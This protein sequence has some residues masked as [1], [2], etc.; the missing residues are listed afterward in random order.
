[1]DA[2]PK[3]PFRVVSECWSGEFQG[4]ENEFEGVKND[5]EGA[6]NDFEGAIL[7]ME[8]EMQDGV[9]AETLHMSQTK[10]EQNCVCFVTISTYPFDGN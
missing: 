4:A 7:Q 9:V 2:P 5:F 10:S 3:C 1:M 8:I 6:K